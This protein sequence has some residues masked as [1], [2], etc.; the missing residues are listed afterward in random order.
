VDSSSLQQR[1]SAADTAHMAARYSR[2][3]AQSCAKS[4]T[5][6]SRDDEILRRG[7]DNA[8]GG[9]T[10][11][12]DDRKSNDDLSAKTDQSALLVRQDLCRA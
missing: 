1:N 10:G 2:S 5:G 3:D 6:S 12:D 8:V 11:I 4:G 7:F 9:E